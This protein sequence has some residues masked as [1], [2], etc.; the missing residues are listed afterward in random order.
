MGS[1][2]NDIFHEKLFDDRKTWGNLAYNY[3]KAVEAEMTQ[4]ERKARALKKA[5]NNMQRVKNAN[6][7][8][9]RT[10][11]VQKNGTLRKIYWPCKWELQGEKCWAHNAKV[12]PYVHKNS[13]EWNDAVEYTKNHKKPHNATAKV[14]FNTA[15]KRHRNMTRNKRRK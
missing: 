5:E 9:R 13:S 2:K 10:R 4:N 8:K 6:I 7:E 12:C 3:N 1:S 11:H 15:G 14:P